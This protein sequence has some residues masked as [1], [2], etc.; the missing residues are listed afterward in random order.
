MVET[1]EAMFAVITFFSPT[2]L[3]TKATVQPKI[4]LDCFDVG[5]LVLEVF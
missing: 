2:T 5:C 1:I 3:M 4:H